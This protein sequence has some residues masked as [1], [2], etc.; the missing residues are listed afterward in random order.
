MDERDGSFDFCFIYIIEDCAC[1]WA[2]L[3]NVALI[4]RET[5]LILQKVVNK[6]R[7]NWSKKQDD[8]L[9]AYRTAYKNHI[10]MSPFEMVYGKACHLPV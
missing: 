2:K 10:G 1:L 8:A 7:K 3:A 5:K 6:S 4:N 9:W